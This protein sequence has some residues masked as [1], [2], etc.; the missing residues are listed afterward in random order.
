[1]RPPRWGGR[2]VT[3]GRN[4]GLAQ[5]LSGPHKW[6]CLCITWAVSTAKQSAWRKGRRDPLG[7]SDM[8]MECL[9]PRN[10]RNWKWCHNQ[11]KLGLECLWCIGDPKWKDP[12]HCWLWKV[13]VRPCTLTGWAF[14]CCLVTAHCGYFLISKL[15]EYTGPHCYKTKGKFWRNVYITGTTV[16]SMLHQQI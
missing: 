6:P 16:K 8:D 11:N 12:T 1:M 3:Q 5:W 15:Q 2:D 4:L 9:L 14:T 13:V 7:C 10:R